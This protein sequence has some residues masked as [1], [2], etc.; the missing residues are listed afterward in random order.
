MYADLPATPILRE[1]KITM[2]SSDQT[3]QQ[4][5]DMR[6]V[7]EASLQ[8]RLRRASRVKLQ[9]FI[10]AHWFASAALECPA[11]YI[12]GHFYGAISVAQAY[13]EAL[14]RFLADHHHIRKSKNI[15]VL[16][17]RLYNEKIISSQ[18]LRAAC[19]IL[20]DRNDFHHLNKQVE[21]DYKK[22][23]AHAEKC[24]NHLYTIESEIFSYK[25]KPGKVTPKKPEYWPPGNFG[26]VQV[27]LKQ[28]L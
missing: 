12:A 1:R 26:F 15:K 17:E 11:M 23:E 25:Y 24:I 21:R 10:P 3:S 5:R 16:C 4:L 2:D 8:H 13:V 6:S 7:F 20:Y 19:A 18:A 28:L 14:S 22:L 9:A 27:T